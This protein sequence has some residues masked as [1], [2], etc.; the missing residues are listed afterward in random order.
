MS[1]LQAP[2]ITVKSWKWSSFAPAFLGSCI[3]LLTI[4]TIG[5]M[6]S[7]NTQKIAKI[8]RP[9]QVDTAHKFLTTQ[10]G[11]N[12]VGGVQERLDSLEAKV[13][14]WEHRSWLMS[15]AVNENANL[16]KQRHNSGYVTFD[17]NWKLSS[18]P[19]TMKLPAETKAK[20]EA[21]LIK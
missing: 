14:T 5:L 2:P 6:A 13:T 19:T 9:I 21:D 16:S 1:V 3:I 20:L 8:D 7:K 15:L 4:A 18:V 17:E 11:E 10:D 12:M